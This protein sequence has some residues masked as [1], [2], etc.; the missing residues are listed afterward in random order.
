MGGWGKGGLFGEKFGGFGRPHPPWSIGSR[1]VNSEG[2][3]EGPLFQEGLLYVEI[4]GGL[5]V[6]EHIL[7][8]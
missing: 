2:Y 5:Y 8:A 3:K 1:G 4:R 6:Y 7:A